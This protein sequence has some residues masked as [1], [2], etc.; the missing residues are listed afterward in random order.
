M[1]FRSSR[2]S[3]RG[4]FNSPATCPQSE[5]LEP[6]PGLST[7]GRYSRERQ[8]TSTAYMHKRAWIYMYISTVVDVI[9]HLVDNLSIIIEIHQGPP[10]V[11]LSIF[12]FLILCFISF[13]L[14][15]LFL[16]VPRGLFKFADKACER[17]GTTDW[18]EVPKRLMGQPVNTAYDM[19]YVPFSHL[20]YFPSNVQH[21]FSRSSIISQLA[22][23]F[24]RL[25]T[26]Q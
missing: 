6:V 2:S 14:S 7:T 22:E 25:K 8:E 24:R 23:K 3:S 15:L 5:D 1:G 11:R 4:L 13:F 12:I 20:L 9:V 17:Q 16:F 10:S 19:C 18:L 21:H 26:P